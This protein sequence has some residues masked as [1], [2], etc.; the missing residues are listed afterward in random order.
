METNAIKCRGIKK[1]YGTNDNRILA[2]NGIDL[3][4]ECNKLTLLVGPS[5]SGKTTLLSIICNI[6]T[7]DEGQLFL[8]GHDVNR[9]TENEKAE[10]HRDNLGIIF[11]SLFF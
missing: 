9:M 3:D 1:S 11:Q 7:P 5:G 4:V 8:L 6:L 2:L 10:F